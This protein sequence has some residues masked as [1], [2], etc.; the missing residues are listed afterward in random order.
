[1]FRL[2]NF[3]RVDFTVGEMVNLMTVD[4]QKCH[5]LLTYLNVVWSGPFQIIVSL[6]YLYLLM[7][8]SVLAGMG[9]LLLF[10]PLSSCFSTYE[11]K[12]QARQMV[13]KDRRSK[14]MNEI[15]AGINVLK[16]Y[17]WEDSFIAKIMNFRN[18]ELKLIKKAMLL[19]ANHSFSL[20]LAPFLVSFS[21]FSVYVLLGNT[22]TAEKAFVAISLFNILR[23]PLFLL[24]MVIANIAQFRVSAKRLSKFLKSEELD[25]ISQTAYTDNENAIEIRNGTFKWSD[26]G[27]AILQNINLKVPCG[28]LTAIVGQVGSGKSSLVSAILGEIKKV[29]GDVFVKDSISYVSQQPWIQ[30]KSL[31][32]NIVFVSDYE[33]KRYNKVVDACALKPDIDSLAGGDRTEIGEKGINLS[34]GQKQRVSI[35]RAVYHNSELYIMDDPL[36]A[37]DA[38]V[39]KH[40]FDHVIGSK[41]LLKS[42]VKKMKIDF[43][44]KYFIQNVKKVSS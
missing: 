17:S 10:I 31:R 43:C 33:T 38:H 25:P 9:V 23:F 15:L 13:Y 4:T 16:L 11:K 2:N 14:L 1:M 21:T 42:K 29:S 26:H 7:G 30:N 32:D 22:L 44:Y 28:S 39:G 6:V 18:D 12:F 36:S 34:G 5:D 19:Q 41:G 35:A 37:V 3:G 24:P 40:I 8:W 27:E 20:T